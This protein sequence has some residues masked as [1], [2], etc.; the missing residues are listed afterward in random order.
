MV[1]DLQDSCLNHCAVQAG[2]RE[3]VSR[4]RGIGPEAYLNGASQEPTP[5]DAWLP[6]RR[7]YSSERRAAILF[8]LAAL[9]SA[10]SR[11]ASGIYDKG[12]P[13][14]VVAVGDS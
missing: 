12:V 4:Y 8:A 11:T 7:V 3:I 6:A 14:F 9:R 13:S 5:K 2:H 1:T 10:Q